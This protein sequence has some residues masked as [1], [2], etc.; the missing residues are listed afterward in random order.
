[1]KKQKLAKKEKESPEEDDDEEEEDYV[2]TFSESYSDASGNRMIIDIVLQYGQY[3]TLGQATAK[4]YRVAAMEPNTVG[5]TF[6]VS[7]S[8]IFVVYIFR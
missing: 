2:K 3:E 1:M 8:R 4:A 5:F 6:F 7:M